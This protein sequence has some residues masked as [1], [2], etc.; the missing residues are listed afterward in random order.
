MFVLLVVWTLPHEVI[1]A[2]HTQG[3]LTAFPVWENE[4]GDLN[5]DGDTV[6]A[7]WHVHDTRTGL[8]A[9]LHLAAALV[10]TSLSCTPAAPVVAKNIAAVLVSEAGQ[11]SG[12]LNGDA[13]TGD[14]IMAVY[15]A[16]T[17][18]TTVVPVA[19][20]Q[21]V[22]RDVS[23]FTV[24]VAPVIAGTTAAVLVSESQ[25]GGT[26]LNGDTDQDDVV[27][28]LFDVETGGL[29]NLGLAAATIPGPFG[30]R[31][32]IPLDTSGQRVLIVVGETEQG[33]SDINQDGDATDQ[34]SMAINVK[35]GRINVS[36]NNV[37]AGR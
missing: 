2:Q 24:P 11:G 9:N 37:H 17:G 25:Q 14:V 3:S 32:P 10:C 33:A 26:D 5:G 4:A 20:A 16:R 22:G 29:F 23:S 35:N 19:V 27:L 30:S 31:N 7:V 21:A 34:I 15:D 36:G 28:H 1:G 18:A 8:T 12:D 13:D 6:D